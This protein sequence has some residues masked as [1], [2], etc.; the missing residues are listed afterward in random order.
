MTGKDMMSWVIVGYVITSLTRVGA[1]YNGA[2]HQ[3]CQSFD[4]VH[5][6]QGPNPVPY[7][8]QVTST[9]TYTNKQKIDLQ[10]KG[11]QFTGLILQAR[12]VSGASDWRPVGWFSVPFDSSGLRLMSCVSDGDTI[13]QSTSFN[14]LN[15]T[16][17][18]WIAPE[19]DEGDIYF[20]ANVLKNKDVWYNNIR[21]STNLKYEPSPTTI[22]TASPTTSSTTITTTTAKR[23][24]YYSGTP[25]SIQQGFQK[26]IT[27]G[28]FTIMADFLLLP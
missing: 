11:T 18:T 13:T 24:Y 3:S 6:T 10:I 20:M 8:I 27:I 7:S 5:G 22:T 26:F 15:G 1:F 16:M 9:N 23:P 12:R 4:P 14:S 2:P 19:R 21:S 17:M 28:L 25:P